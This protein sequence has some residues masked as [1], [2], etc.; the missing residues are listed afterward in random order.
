[1]NVQARETTTQA[2]NVGLDGDFARRGVAL[3][4]AGEEQLARQLIAGAVL[5]CGC[6][7][8]RN[9]G[10]LDKDGLRVGFDEGMQMKISSTLPG[11]AKN[12]VWLQQRAGTDKAGSLEKVSASHGTYPW[13]RSSGTWGAIGHVRA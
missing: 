6:T 11:T 5:F 10:Q 7:S 9:R 8:V 2:G 13:L 3:A 1:M 12:E 4:V